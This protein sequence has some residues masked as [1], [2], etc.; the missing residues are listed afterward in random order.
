MPNRNRNT[1]VEN[2]PMDK[3]GAMG[4]GMNEEVGVDIHTAQVTDEGLPHGSGNTTRRSA[5]A[6]VGRESTI[7]RMP[8][9]TSLITLL[10]SGKEHGI[11][12]LLYK[13]SLSKFK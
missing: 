2:N 3:W 13:N 1:D 6:S 4:V 12:K 11:A 10:H 9:H 8:V 7:E 5:V